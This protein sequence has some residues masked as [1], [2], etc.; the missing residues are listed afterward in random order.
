MS[1]RDMQAATR[2]VIEETSLAFSVPISVLRTSRHQRAVLARAAAATVMRDGMNLTWSTVSR[3]L[4]YHHAT[5]IHHVSLHKKRMAEDPV[6]RRGFQQ[7]LDS[8][9][10]KGLFPT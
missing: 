3:A 2:S 6:Y 10:E 8:L 1:Q 5:M 4:G 7:L 9:K